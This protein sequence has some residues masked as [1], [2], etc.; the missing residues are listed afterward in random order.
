MIWLL[1]TAWVIGSIVLGI[2]LGLFLGRI[3]QRWNATTNSPETNQTA[4]GADWGTWS[5]T[6]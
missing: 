4:P 2:A 6:T 3:E 5:P 1:L